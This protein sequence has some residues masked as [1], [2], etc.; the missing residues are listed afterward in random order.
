[1]GSKFS[2]RSDFEIPESLIDCH[3]W[4]ADEF[5][6]GPTGQQCE[7]VY[8]FTKNEV[9]PNCKFDPRTKRSSG[10]YKT[11]QPATGPNI[12]FPNHTTCPWCG[13]VGRSSRATTSDIRFRVYWRASDLRSLSGMSGVVFSDSD[14]DNGCVIIGYMTDLPAVEK[15]A[16]VNV[17]KNVEGFRKWKCERR[18]EASP[19]G[20]RQDRY[21]IQ[22][23]KRVGGG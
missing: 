2:N 20:F 17:N 4:M 6:D 3:E 16:Y 10:I 11:D 18:G 21:F 7:L 1:M 14:F 13:G 23:L 15:A 9:C 5:I 12:P 22:F 19:W 8:P